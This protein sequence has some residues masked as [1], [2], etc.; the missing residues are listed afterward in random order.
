MKTIFIVI[1]SLLVYYIGLIL[2]TKKSLNKK[3]LSLN[4]I[5]VMILPIF[6]LWTLVLLAIK[7]KNVKS[8]RKKA[9]L[10]ILFNFSISLAVM[11]EL[12]DYSIETGNIQVTKNEKSKVYGFF[13]PFGHSSE[14][15]R[16]KT[17]LFKT[18]DN[19]IL[20]N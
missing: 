2:L 10:G 3:N 15:S 17:N 20:S 4:F 1:V 14:N 9:V 18:I 8:K 13:K 11:I 12:I 19:Y 16:L 7:Y 6:I 5:I